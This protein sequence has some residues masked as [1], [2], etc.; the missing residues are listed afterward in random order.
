LSPTIS[1]LL[2]QLITN[3]LLLPT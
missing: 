3:K 2:A 1:Q